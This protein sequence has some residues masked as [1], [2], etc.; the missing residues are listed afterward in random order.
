MI[1]IYLLKKKDKVVYV[2]QSIN[3]EQRIKKHKKSEKK[4][5]DYTITLSIFDTYKQAQQTT[6]DYKT[7]QSELEELIIQ[8]IREFR[9]RYLWE[10]SQ[11][12]A[13]KE[14]F[15]LSTAA[16]IVNLTLEEKIGN[17]LY[18]GIEGAFVVRVFTNCDVGTFNY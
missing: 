17:D 6:K 18:V 10:T 15:M 4:F 8:F 5:D 3:I 14:W 16:E 9:S 11:S 2:G 12:T 7:K 13:N 1:G